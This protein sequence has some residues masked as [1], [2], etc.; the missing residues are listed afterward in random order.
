MEEKKERM[1]LKD[2]AMK[3]Y[4]QEKEKCDKIMIE[5]VCELIKIDRPDTEIMRLID[6]Y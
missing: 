4:Q 5:E 1:S 3:R 6:T 2:I